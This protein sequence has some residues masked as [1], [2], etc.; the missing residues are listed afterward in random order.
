MPAKME[1]L[2][3]GLH[4]Q[5]NRAFLTE[6]LCQWPF[7]ACS[8][9]ASLIASF[10]VTH[11]TR[12]RARVQCPPAIRHNLPSSIMYSDAQCR[13]CFLFCRLVPW[14]SSRRASITSSSIGTSWKWSLRVDISSEP[15]FATWNKLCVSPAV[16]SQS[17]DT[18]HSLP[19]PSSQGV[20]LAALLSPSAT[21]LMRPGTWRT[22]M[23]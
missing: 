10:G 6:S 7:L 13:A 5:S 8:S 20:P 2:R 4:I 17:S 1:P 21:T 16:A 12:V 22:S 9:L 3:P 11:S 15:A 19:S 23:I 14:S 18:V